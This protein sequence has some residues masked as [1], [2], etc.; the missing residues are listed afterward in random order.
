MSLPSDVL[1]ALRATFPGDALITDPERAL[2][3]GADAS[4]R[5]AAPEAVVRPGNLEQT[6]ELL[7][8]AHHYGV[9]LYP[10]GRGTNRVGACVPTRPGIVVSCSKLNRIMEI[11]GEDFVA[12]CEP[13]VITGDLQQACKARGLLYP[14][15]PAS[16]RYSTIGGNVAQNAGGMRAL[17]Y[18]TTRDFVLGVTA[19]LPGGAV[20]RLGSRCHK[21]VAGLDLARLFAGSE[22]T[23]G[24]MAGVTLK[25]LPHPE[26]SASLMAAFASE[27]DALS[28]A[29]AVFAAGILPVAMEFMP[30]E[31]TRALE[32]GAD[33]PWPK[34]PGAALLFS[35][36]GSPE[37]VAADLARLRRAVDTARPSWTGEANTPP[38]EESLW[39]PRRQVSQAAHFYGPSK[40]S[41]DIAV[42]RGKVGEAVA[43]IRRLGLDAGLTI[44]AFGHLGDGNLHVSV[45]HD[46]KDEDQARRAAEA[47][48]SVLAMALELDGTITGEHGVGLTKLAWLERMRGPETVALMHAVK[49]A[50]D[51]KGIMNPGKAY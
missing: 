44:L 49:A 7:R 9:P 50:F 13:G 19:V 47:R 41:D 38:E 5:L 27:E 25:L 28:A 42:P 8:I 35:L 37:A 22:G 30:E 39:E 17:K 26:A 12:V 32:H 20:T 23:L 3:F 46:A 16:A 43:R 29:N 4:R 48:Q 6:V 11:S 33:A 31:V 1:R 10:R 34:G 36:D 40:L 14:P 15:D 24:F 21:D 51:P 45:M 2:V 18:G